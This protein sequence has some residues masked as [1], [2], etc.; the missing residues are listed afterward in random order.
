MVNYYVYLLQGNILHCPRQALV[1]WCR[2]FSIHIC[3]TGYFLIF[4]SGI[5]FLSSGTRGG[6]RK[7]RGHP[8]T[9]SHGTASPGTP[10]SAGPRFCTRFKKQTPCGGPRRGRKR[11]GTLRSP[12]ASG[13]PLATPLQQIFLWSPPDP[14]KELCP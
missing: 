8:R 6:E 1:V 10:C 11:W 7:W 3:F 9:P 14:N 12:P 13:E 5:I 2:G 4:S